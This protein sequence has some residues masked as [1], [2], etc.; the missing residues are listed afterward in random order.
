MIVFAIF[1]KGLLTS[2]T[3]LYSLDGCGR[4]GRARRELS[5]LAIRDI[6]GCATAGVRGSGTDLA[7]TVGLAALGGEDDALLRGLNTDRL[8]VREARVL[9]GVDTRQVVRLQRQLRATLAHSRLT[10]ELT[11]Q[12]VGRGVLHHGPDHIR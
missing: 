4:D 3:L 10:A 1:R 11:L 7:D 9:E 2:A 8:R 5:A 12:E 6:S